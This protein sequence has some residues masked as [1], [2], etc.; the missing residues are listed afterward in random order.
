MA[1]TVT[2][3]GMNQE[4][5]RNCLKGREQVSKTDLAALTGLS[6]PTVSRTIDHLVNTGEVETVGAGS[7]SGGRCAML[8]RLNPLHAVYLLLTIERG[9]LRWK[10]KDLGGNVLAQASRQREGRLWEAI[11]E[12]AQ[13]IK[14]LYPQLRAVVIGAAGMVSKGRLMLSEGDQELE[15]RDL[16]GFFSER[17]EVPVRAVNDMNAAA[18]GCWSRTGMERGACVCLYLGGN[19]MGAGIVLDG[20]VWPGAADFAGELGFLPDMKERLQP[21]NDA[22]SARGM[23]D[24]YRRIIQTYAVLLNPERIV[25]YTNPFLEGMMEELYEDCSRYLPEYAVPLLELSDDFERDYEMGM[26]EIAGKME[27]RQKTEF[28]V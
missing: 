21:W 18:A 22:F 17:L 7:S 10:L 25:L 4:I 23:Q 2:V 11:G 5:I 20:R 3:R 1:S 13:S 15:G 26:M 14:G 27:W 16:E 9:R 8:Y 19:G 12:T 28:M 6:F 24:V